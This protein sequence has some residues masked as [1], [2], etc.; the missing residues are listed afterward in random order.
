MQRPEQ[1][2]ER[3][4]GEGDE[5]LAEANRPYIDCMHEVLQG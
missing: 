3:D 1:A 4:H 2:D 5:G